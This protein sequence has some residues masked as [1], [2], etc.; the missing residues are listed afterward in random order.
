MGTN[1]LVAPVSLLPNLQRVLAGVWP[2][3]EVPPLWDGRTADRAVIELR[4]RAG[5]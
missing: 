3:G 2:S 4:R 5:A 1:K